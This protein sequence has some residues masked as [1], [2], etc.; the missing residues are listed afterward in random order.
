MTRIFTMRPFHS[1]VVMGLIAFGVACHSPTS[2]D[3][4]QIPAQHGRLSGVVTIGPNCPGPQ[5]NNNP[6]PT[7]PSAYA[8]RKILVYTQTN[9]NLLF[10]VDIDS[11]GA[12]LID[13]APAKYMV[14]LKPNGIDRTSD[15]PQV[16]EIRANTVT[17][18]DV[19]IDTGIR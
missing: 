7:Q 2:P 17:R 10:T 3:G 11:Q 8:A 5:Q 18:L 16:I 13:L 15:L 4:G 9:S 6:C 1:I 12:Y 14:E 19:S